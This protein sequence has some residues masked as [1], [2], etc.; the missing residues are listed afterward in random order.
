VI[1]FQQP[2]RGMMLGA[3]VVLLAL[4]AIHAEAADS[5]FIGR[6]L[7]QSA[8]SPETRPATSGSPSS[9]QG[10]KGMSGPQ[11]QPKAIIEKIQPIQPR[12]SIQP[13]E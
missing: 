10:D 4:L 13:R 8:S 3:L 2:V 1:W 7:P 11:V 5:V 6:P 12:E 9:T